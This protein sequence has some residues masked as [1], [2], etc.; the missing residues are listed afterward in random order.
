M[1][2]S[3]KL[4]KRGTGI[5]LVSATKL[6]HAGGVSI[7]QGVFRMDQ[8]SS[9]GTGPVWIVRTADVKPQFDLSKAGTGLV[10]T[11][12]FYILGPK[13]TTWDVQN[14]NDNQFNGKIIA[15]DDFWFTSCWSNHKYNGTTFNATID[16]PGHTAT[17]SNYGWLLNGKSNASISFTT[18]NDWNFTLGAKFKGTDSDATLTTVAKTFFQEGAKWPGH[19]AVKTASG[20]TP[21]TISIPAGVKIRVGSLAVGGVEQPLGRYRKTSAPAGSTPGGT[22]VGDGTL[23]VGD[24][25]LFL[26]IR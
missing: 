10:L 12:D 24:P 22:F 18:A 7:E 20:K 14:N 11:N 6:Q 23:V 5:F 19:V 21:G 3:G 15:E 17:F 26:L 9:L 8:K 1:T 4:V 2:G 16:A 25:G 13:S